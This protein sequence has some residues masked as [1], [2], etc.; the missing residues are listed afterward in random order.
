M[1]ILLKYR[2][3]MEMLKLLLMLLVLSLIHIYSRSQSIHVEAGPLTETITSTGKFGG[4]TAT[5]AVRADSDDV[6]NVNDQ[7]ILTFDQEVSIFEAADFRLLTSTGYVTPSSVAYDV[8]PEPLDTRKDVKTKL[9]L[10]FTDKAVGTN[11]VTVEYNGEYGDKNVFLVDKY[12][13]KVRA[14]SKPVN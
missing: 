2:L 12:G 7:V 6:D 5:S 3:M 8:K 4:T 14:F 11:T 10:Q 1:T 13:S 9:V